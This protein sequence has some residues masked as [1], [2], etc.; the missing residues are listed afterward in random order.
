VYAPQ[1]SGNCSQ[2]LPWRSLGE[3]VEG[4]FRTDSDESYDFINKCLRTCLSHKACNSITSRVFPTRVLDVGKG[5]K[6]PI[7]IHVP[8]KF[9]FKYIALSMSFEHSS[10][11]F[12]SLITK[13]SLLGHR[14]NINNDK[15]QYTPTSRWNQTGGPPCIILRYYPD[16]AQIGYQIRMDRFSLHP[17]R[18]QEGLG[19]RIR[20]NGCHF[21]ECLPSHIS[22][23]ML[24]QLSTDPLT[25]SKSSSPPKTDIQKHNWQRIQ[26]LCS[27]IPRSPS[28]YPREYT[29]STHRTTD[30]TRLGSA[31]THPSNSNPSLHSY[32]TSFRMQNCRFLRMSTSHFNATFKP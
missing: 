31:R 30:D 12:V 8:C 9:G 5:E 15:L 26:T 32:R 29:Y 6:D 21:W 23:R 18:L 19:K 1:F 14:A 3:A 22:S 16:S 10:P 4:S 28:E 27:K 17:P 11:T 20:K 25:A 2:H 24:R 13:R 7:R